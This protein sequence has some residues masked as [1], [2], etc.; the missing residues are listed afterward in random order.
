MYQVIDSMHQDGYPKI[1]VQDFVGQY[2]KTVKAVAALHTRIAGINR[3]AGTL[4]FF[5][6]QAW[7]AQAIVHVTAF[8]GAA[9]EEDDVYLRLRQNGL[10]T[11]K[12]IFI[13]F[14]P[15]ILQF[16]VF[17]ITG[18]TGCGNSENRVFGRAV[19]RRC[20]YRPKTE[21]WRSSGLMI[22]SIHSKAARS[23]KKTKR[24]TARSFRCA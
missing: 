17:G 12:T 22:S 24:L 18:K 4:E 6:N 5:T 14:N 8:S 13:Y 19:S 9:T 21:W 23:R 2:I 20:M 3:I 16:Q 11:N 10:R 1:V 15:V 7:K